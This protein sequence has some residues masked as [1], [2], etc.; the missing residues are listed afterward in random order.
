MN[1]I[2]TELLETQDQYLDLLKK[3]VDKPIE[4]ITRVDV[5]QIN[6][7][8]YEKRNLIELAASYI[9]STKDVFA[10]TGTANFDMNLVD[11]RTF[12]LFGDIRIYDDPLPSY[13]KVSTL[14]NN[15]AFRDAVVRSINISIKAIE[16]FRGQLLVIPLRS[17]FELTMDNYDTFYS[18]AEIL[19]LKEFP[20]IN[21]SAEFDKVKSLHDI[22]SCGDNSLLKMC[23]LFD[24]D[25]LHSS[26]AQ[27][28]VLFKQNSDSS[29][30]AGLSDTQL[31]RQTVCSFL[32]QALAIL[33]MVNQ[34][35]VIPY[36]VNAVAL[37]YVQI[38]I[39]LVDAQEGTPLIQIPNIRLI[40]GK[41]FT[42]FIFLQEYEKTS[43]V[44]SVDQMLAS[45][46]NK[47]LI[48]EMLKV[49]DF[50]DLFDVPKIL[51]K[52]QPILENFVAMD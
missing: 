10:F 41:S 27:R 43:L 30:Y 33:E 15:N 32:A 52:I 51:K 22:E 46:K 37:E 49:K 36:F 20:Q 9:F 39:S 17:L 6:L 35:H 40:I 44:L 48:N 24:G 42:A 14:S 28:I 21:T 45:E 2:S 29:F 19:F 3:I 1:L 16:Q 13:L 23:P 11:R 31:Y 34:F 7:F 26:L 50:D 25:N 4:S 5:D 18:T 47:S 8:W 12:F 38:F